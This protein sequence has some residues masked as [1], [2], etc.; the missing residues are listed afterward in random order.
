[1]LELDALIEEK[2]YGRKCPEETAET[3]DVLGWEKQGDGTYVLYSYNPDVR[4]FYVSDIWPRNFSDNIMLAWNLV[5]RY[6]I[7]ILPITTLEG[8]IVEWEAMSRKLPRFSIT[9]DTAAMAIC[10]LVAEIVKN[11]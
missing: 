7:S 3:S 8:E 2:V 9:G 11:D 1:M 4:G 5:V 6:T 10:L